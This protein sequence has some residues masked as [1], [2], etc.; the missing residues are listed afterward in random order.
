MIGAI[1]SV[2][3]EGPR[4]SIGAGCFWCKHPREIWK[5]RL[6]KAKIL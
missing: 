5:I 3:G 1:T 6:D 2:T 4:A